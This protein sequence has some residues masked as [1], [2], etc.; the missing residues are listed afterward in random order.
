MV[1][2]KGPPEMEGSV[3]PA[4]TNFF[5]WTSSIA[6]KFDRLEHI[7]YLSSEEQNNM[8]KFIQ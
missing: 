1:S 2:A 6:L 7:L 8:K 4:A 5:S 3:S